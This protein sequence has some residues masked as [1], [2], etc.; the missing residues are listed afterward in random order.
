[1]GA[2][3]RAQIHAQLV[4]RLYLDFGSKTYFAGTANQADV[5]F[6]HHIVRAGINYR[7]NPAPVVAKY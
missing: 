5:S 1:V 4:R 2:G 7:F 6:H 3:G